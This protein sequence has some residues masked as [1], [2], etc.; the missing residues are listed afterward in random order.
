M[1]HDLL[2]AALRAWRGRVRPEDVGV[3]HRGARRTPGLRRDEVALLAG[4]S[5]EYVIRLEQGRARHPSQQVLDALARALRL[6]EAEREHLLRLGGVTPAVA[7]EVPRHLPP[8]VHRLLRRLEDVPVAVY[9][10]AWTLLSWN[11]PWTV[12]LGEPQEPGR[13]RNLLWQL[14]TAP[15]EDSRIVR[16]EEERQTFAA[17]AVADLRAA[18][19]RYPADPDM[20]ALVADLRRAS[21][22]FAALWESHA[23]QPQA[24]ARKTIA[25]PEVGLITL[26]CDVLTVAGADV[27]IVVYTAEPGTAEADA[28]AL[29]RVVGTQAF[30]S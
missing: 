30:S 8:S 2:G 13:A 23:V 15:A 5:V 9:D 11:R 19:G 18:Y 14:F 21:H 16:T 12:L 6:S 10:A 3:P 17:S 1:D 22:R 20:Q 28:L 26:D 24:S 27:R 25:H 4:V 7:G 29:L